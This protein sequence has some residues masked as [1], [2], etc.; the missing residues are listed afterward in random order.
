MA[1]QLMG[2]IDPLQTLIYFGNFNG[3]LFNLVDPTLLIFGSMKKSWCCYFFKKSRN[4]LRNFFYTICPVNF[5]YIFQV[6][7]DICHI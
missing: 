5:S 6:P 2:F 3:N 7:Q 4:N 1:M